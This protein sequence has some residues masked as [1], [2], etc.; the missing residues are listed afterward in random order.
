MLKVNVGDRLSERIEEIGKTL[1]GTVIYVHPKGRFCTVE[2]KTR[3]GSF[4]ESFFMF[5]IKE[6]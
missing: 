4:R 1:T 3:T 6:K 5:R 2:F